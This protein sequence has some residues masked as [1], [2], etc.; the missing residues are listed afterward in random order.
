MMLIGTI[1]VGRLYF[2]MQSLREVTAAA[3]RHAMIDASLSGCAQPAAEV[4]SMTPFLRPA[5]LNLCVT[6]GVSAGRVT[7]IVEAGYRYTSVL[8][9][10]RIRDDELTDRST[11]TFTGQ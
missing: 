4:A 2:T 7:I 3:A 1:E 6:R 8:S 11:M 9:V 5:S 10:L